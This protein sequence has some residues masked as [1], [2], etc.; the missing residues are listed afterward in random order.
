MA[1]IYW[2]NRKITLPG[3]YSRII[4]GESQPPRVSDFGTVLIIDTG[5]FGAGFG[6]GS[7]I[8]GQNFQGQESIY[9]FSTISEFRDFVK[10]GAWW[11]MAEKLFSPDPS[12][13]QANGV[14]QL[15]YVRAAK[16]TSATITLT[17]TAGGTFAVDTLDEGLYPNG[18]MQ[19]GN[20]ITGYGANCIPGVEDPTKYIVQFW[21]GTYTG[22]AED[23]Y[24]WGDTVASA[25]NPT[26]VLQSPE[27]STINELID[28]AQNGSDFGEV[29]TLNSASK[30]QG[31]GTIQEEDVEKWNVSTYI[32]AA[33]GTETFNADYF[34]DVLEQ[35]KPL[36]YSFCIIDQFGTNANSSLVK[37]Y[38]AHNSTEAKFTHFLFVGGYDSKADFDKSCK[39]AQGFNSDTVCLVHGAAGMQSAFGNRLRWYGVMYNLC[40]IVGRTAGKAPYIPVTNKSIGID[41]LMHSPSDAEAEKAIKYGV[42]VTRWNTYVNKYVV[43]QGINTLQDNDVLFNTS[44]QSYSIQFMRIVAQINKELVINSELDLLANENGVNANTLSEGAIKNWTIAYLQARVATTQQDNLILGFQDVAATRQGEAWFV[45]YKIRVNNEIN[46]LFFT[47][48]LIS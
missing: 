17:T 47:G 31:D 23:G 10:G 7:G 3:A 30:P 14:S 43:L 48:Y 2:N 39:L 6:G 32:L 16:T 25:A 21:R 40:A 26:L 12:N 11:R 33:G 45:T 35:I 46:K 18:K 41:K 4:S 36:D 24:P 15:M 1:S 44:G 22:N 34:N 19:D 9:S 5:V 20:L 13:S 42:L 8:D 38:M 29:F 28:W 27:V 37:S